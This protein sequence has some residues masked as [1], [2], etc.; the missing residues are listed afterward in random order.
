MAEEILRRGRAKYHTSKG[1]DHLKHPPPSGMNWRL[2]T[3][4]ELVEPVNGVVNLQRK[5]EERLW[6]EEHWAE[7]R[8]EEKR[9]WLAEMEERAARE[10]LNSVRGPRPPTA[11]DGTRRQQ[12]ELFRNTRGRMG[13]SPGFKGGA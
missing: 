2:L 11:A 13:S 9:K 3:E 5:S 12:E 1:M 4:C 8:A 7:F 6:T 10:G